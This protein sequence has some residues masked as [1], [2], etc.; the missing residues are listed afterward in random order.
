M[1]SRD[2]RPLD[3]LVAELAQ[4]HAVERRWRSRR[5][6]LT[7]FRSG[8]EGATLVKVVADQPP[9]MAPV[10]YDVMLRCR[11]AAGSGSPSVMPVP[12]A[13]GRRPEYIA[14]RWTEGRLL[15]G[16]VDALVDEPPGPSA[17]TMF[18]L[19]RSSGAALARFHRSMPADPTAPAAEPGAPWARRLV[20]AVA[21]PPRTCAVVV[22]SV[23]DPGPHNAVLGDD[24]TLTMIDPPAIVTHVHPEEDL[25]VLAFH[26][27]WRALRS[28]GPPIDVA[29]LTDEIVTGYLDE[30]GDLATSVDRRGIEF[31]FAS[32]AISALKR[33]L[34]RMVSR[35]GGWR[36]ARPALI[37]RHLGW[38]VRS[39]R[40]A[41]TL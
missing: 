19:A 2:R 39:L 29:V 5:G 17:P 28:G 15:N 22:R 37:P 18:D 12:V 7:L 36:Q 27:G 38:C 13:W 25:G 20:K 30:V 35:G 24:G 40:R 11:A 21:G 34:A 32:T 33:R 8:T 9:D 3:A 26:L 1:L 16:V 4:D 6:E 31:V 23:R 14:Y 10:A 41:R